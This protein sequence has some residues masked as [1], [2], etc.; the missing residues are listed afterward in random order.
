MDE[1]LS[2]IEDSSSETPQE[3]DIII[4]GGHSGPFMIM[5]ENRF[6]NC[7]ACQKRYELHDYREGDI[8]RQIVDGSICSGRIIRCGH[9]IEKGYMDR[10]FRGDRQKWFTPEGAEMRLKEMFG[11]RG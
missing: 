4:R 9:P 3:S 1:F 11:E 10:I 8:C 2:I 7:P 6:L 5:A